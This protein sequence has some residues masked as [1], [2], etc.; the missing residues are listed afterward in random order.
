MERTRKINLK[1]RLSVLLLLFLAAWFCCSSAFAAGESLI[2]V[3]RT[4]GIEL[5][6]PGALVVGL[7]DS[8]GKSPAGE[9]GVR[10]GDLITALDGKPVGS[11]AEFMEAASMLRSDTVELTVQRGDQTLSFQVKPMQTDEGRK[12]GVWLRDSISGIGTVTFVDPE[13][14]FYGALGHPINDMDTGALM[15]LGSGI[16]SD[17]EIVG[18]R[19]GRSGAPGELYGRFNFEN[20]CGSILSNTVCGIFGTLEGYREGEALP[21]ADTSEVHTGKATIL[22]NVQGC[23]VAAYEIEIEQVWQGDVR[24]LC[25][26]VKDEALLALTGGIVQGMSGSPIIQDGKLVGAVTHVLVNDPTRGYG[27]FIENMLEAAG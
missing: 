26:S 4:V 1:H 16:V 18:V 23:E 15:P 27:I 22:S 17:A 9:A 21:V 7:T 19:R 3:G 10:A 24:N 14:G 11:S 12:I 8:G 25:F 13:T 5:R 20:S 2:P 6:T